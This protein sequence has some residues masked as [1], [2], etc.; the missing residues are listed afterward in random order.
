MGSAS[1]E[2]FFNAGNLRLRDAEGSWMLISCC[3]VCSLKHLVGCCE[4]REASLY[5]TL[6]L[7]RRG[8]SYVLS[9]KGCNSFKLLPHLWMHSIYLLS[10]P[11]KQKPM[12]VFS[13]VSSSVFKRTCFQGGKGIGLQ[14]EA[15]MLRT[16]NEAFNFRGRLVS[17]ESKIQCFLRQWVLLKHEKH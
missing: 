15:S 7:S 12:D 1:S 16:A 5:R 3:L 9:V 13:E 11:W 17:S 2:G 10:I 4:K 6:A 8:S 14:H